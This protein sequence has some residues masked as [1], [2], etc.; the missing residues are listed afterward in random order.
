MNLGLTRVYLKH[1]DPM[2]YQ[3]SWQHV[4]DEIMKL[5]TGPSRDRWVGCILFR[6]FDFH[7]LVLAKAEN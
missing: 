1:S 2:V 7:H 4:M 5:K 6:H 3:R